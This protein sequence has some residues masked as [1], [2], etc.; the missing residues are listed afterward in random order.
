LKT[1]NIRHILLLIAAVALICGGSFVNTTPVHAQ[2]ANI[3]ERITYGDSLTRQFTANIDAFLFSFYGTTG[4]T[5]TLTMVAHPANPTETAID[6]ALVLL[7]P[8]G[9]VAAQNDDSLD[10]KFGLT[11]ARLTN[12]PIAVSGMYTIRATRSSADL[13]PSGGF[14]LAIKGQRANGG[15]VNL[16]ADQPAKGTL[17]NVI[18]AISYEF[19][20]TGGDVVSA[21][22]DGDPGSNLSLTLLDPLNAPLTTINA[23]A[24]GVVKLTS[25]LLTANSIYTIQI[26]PAKP[27]TAGANQATQTPAPIAPTAFTLTVH[28][29]G[30]G[31]YLPYGGVASGKISTPNPETVYIFMGK[32]GEVVTITMRSVDSTLAAHLKLMTFTGRV[33]INAQASTGADLKQGDA[34]ILHFKL[35]SNAIYMITAGRVGGA[36]GTSSGAFD[37]SLDLVTPVS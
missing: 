4:D 33:L 12:F 34:R 11:N 23:K 5:I 36:T 27:V 31:I 19:R 18:P 9:T 7:A 10:P 6:P 21:E 13:T 1:L 14:I 24:S 25:M 15:R 8:D 26:A 32:A 22:V 3:A 29:D 37:L 28:R 35:T 2:T 17:D 20:A 16:S 30:G